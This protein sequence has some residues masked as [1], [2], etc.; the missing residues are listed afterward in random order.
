M[1]TLPRMVQETLLSLEGLPGAW[2]IWMRAG[3][4][5]QWL[6]AAWPLVCCD[7]RGADCPSQGRPSP[8]S[9]LW[10]PWPLNSH[11][12]SPGLCL[13]SHPRVRT[14]EVLSQ[15]SVLCHWSPRYRL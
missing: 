12:P 8:H 4:G 2:T 3:S 15:H 9:A 7:H 5:G 6:G 14:P 13:W 11:L 10:G 1:D